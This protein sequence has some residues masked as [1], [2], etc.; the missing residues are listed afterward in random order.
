[1][2]SDCIALGALADELDSALRGARVNKI[3]Q[4]EADEIR[5]F[6][7][8]AGGRNPVLVISCNAGAPRMHFTSS[9]KPNPAGAPAFC[10]LLRKHLGTAVVERVFLH[11]NDRIIGIMFSARTE[12]KDK[13]TF[14][15]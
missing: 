14:L 3:V 9:Q 11:E 2:A 13:A 10:M 8:A 5:L 15:I 6:F 12:M 1:M 4:P 7:R